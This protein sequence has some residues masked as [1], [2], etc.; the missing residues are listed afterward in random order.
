VKGL[1]KNPIYL[2]FLDR[3][4][5]NSVKAN[6]SDSDILD[7]IDIGLLLTTQ[8]VYI[9]NSLLWENVSEFPLAVNYLVELEKFKEVLFLSNH[10]TLDEFVS[11]RQH[12]YEKDK[13]RYPMYFSDELE[14]KPWGKNLI[15]MHDSTTELLETN[16][17]K[18]FTP[19]TSIE[20]PFVHTQFGLTQPVLKTLENALTNRNGQAI[21]F[22][23]FSSYLPEST[24]KLENHWT[25][26]RLI[27]LLYTKRYLNFLNGT[28]LTGIQNIQFFDSLSSLPLFYDF[29]IHR[30][31]FNK[32][33]LLLLNNSDI[34]KRH[35]HILAIKNH[36][37]FEDLLIETRAL[38]QGLFQHSIGTNGPATNAFLLKN[39]QKM[40]GTISSTPKTDI[41]SS[42]FAYLLS[43]NKQMTKYDKFK[44]GYNHVKELSTR[45]KILLITA[46]LTELKLLRDVVTE[47]GIAINRFTSGT[48]TYFNFELG[49]NDVYV[50]K[51][52]MGS[53]GSGGSIIA[54]SE[55]ISIIDPDFLIMVGIA[56]G[57]KQGKQSVGDILVSRQLWSYEPAKLIDGHEIPRGDKVTASTLLL[58]RFQISSLDWDKSNVEFGLI[59]SGEKLVNSKEHVDKLLRS[60]PEA[61]GGE[62]EGTGLLSVC[63]HEKKHW[64]LVKAICDW[65]YEKTGDY[66]ELAACNAMEYVLQTISNYID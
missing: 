54:I 31:I 3:E 63:E 49:A 13:L 46:T 42:A 44:E 37:L 59:V 64:I 26:R 10:I 17:K 27:S 5:R 21:T 58:D 19:K 66:Q 11:S 7:L 65:G 9:N 53:V 40:F 52:E 61:I 41:V 12:L 50:F 36:K 57:L 32:L 14:N 28:I 45:K 6:L 55:A 60:E 24:D 18:L 29:V 38:I 20:L 35:A 34:P 15:Y 23:L 39:L 33:N 47:K 2:H 62:M 8:T 56:F 22:S 4:L 43:I 25:I 48:H 51:S 1:I 30:Y 16:L